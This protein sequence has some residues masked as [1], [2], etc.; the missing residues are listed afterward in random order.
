[1]ARPLRIEFP[2]ALYHVTSRGNERA[3]IFFTD[4][5]RRDFLSILGD[6]VEQYHWQCHAYCLMPNHYHLL[7]Q[8]PEPNLS[9]GM[10][11]LN[12][13]YT[14]RLNRRHDRVGHLFQGRFKAILVDREGH[15]LELARYV[16]LNPVRAAMV[17][18]PEEYRWSSLGATLGRARA[19]RWLTVGP[20]VRH[21]GSRERYREFVLEGIGLGAPWTEVR[22]SLL[23][24]DGFARSMGRH[25]E[26]KAAQTEFPRGER[27]A[28][29][30]PLG[31]LFPP[32][33]L[34]DRALRDRRIRAVSRTCAYSL[35]DIARHLGLHRSTVSKIA[36]TQ[37]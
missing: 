12:G 25:V 15:L 37:H 33:V 17:H 13:T 35:A 28:H 32:Q 5:D 9:R 31:R 23:G 27:V 24:A 34:R 7:L 10:H 22:G 1:M 29:H 3:P 8:T 18:D 6:V 36:G 11:Q 30:E 21:F 16:V 14:Q 19:E 2:G 26:E 20:L 4:H